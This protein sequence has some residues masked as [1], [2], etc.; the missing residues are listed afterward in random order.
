MTKIDVRCS[1]KRTFVRILP[2]SGESVGDNSDEEVDEPEVEDN[3][4]DDEE[5]AGDEELGVHHLVH[6]RRPLQ[7]K[8]R[9][10]VSWVSA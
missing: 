2:D 1:T 7:S 4:A 9:L 6:Q 3:Y 5:E 8:S 10:V